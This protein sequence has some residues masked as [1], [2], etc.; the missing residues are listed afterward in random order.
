MPGTAI[1]LGYRREIR[2]RQERRLHENREGDRLRRLV[3]LGPEGK[4]IADPALVPA[5][6]SGP[7]SVNVCYLTFS[8]KAFAY[9]L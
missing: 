4:H 2:A 7:V 1:C 8:G 6:R 9:F 5:D 3:F